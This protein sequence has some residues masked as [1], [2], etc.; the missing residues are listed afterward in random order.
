MLDKLADPQPCGSYAVRPPKH[1]SLQ[2]IP[3]Q[4]G[5]I[6]YA[7]AMGPRAD[8]SR[9]YILAV[10]MPPNSHPEL[11][12]LGDML[13]HF[14]AGI[15]QHLTAFKASPG[16]LGTINGLAFARRYWVG[17]NPATGQTLHG[18]IYA[19]RDGRSIVELSS[20]DVEPYSDTLLPLT[21]ASALTFQKK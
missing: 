5:S 17:N 8:S 4:D 21:E 18:F 16:E 6:A 19:S 3:Q 11:H 9:S 14:L 2:T 13:D 12:T 10:V 7:W 20:Q 1:Y 15:S